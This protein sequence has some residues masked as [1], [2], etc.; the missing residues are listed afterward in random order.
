[1][2]EEFG[3]NWAKEAEISD[4]LK[5]G[6]IVGPVEKKDLHQRYQRKDC[7]SME[8]STMGIRARCE[9]AN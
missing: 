5:E 2:W 1:M 7:D 4:L 3:A 9:L 8:N 6:K